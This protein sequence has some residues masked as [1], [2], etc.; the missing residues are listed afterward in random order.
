MF[1]LYDF[2]Y[3]II[4]LLYNFNHPVVPKVDLATA[5]IMY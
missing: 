3:I 5:A 2:N 4:C 1:Y